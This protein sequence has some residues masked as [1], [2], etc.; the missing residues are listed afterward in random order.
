MWHDVWAPVIVTLASSVGS[1]G[2]VYFKRLLARHFIGLAALSKKLID[3]QHRIE[4][5]EA[6][7]T[8]ITLDPATKVNGDADRETDA[9]PGRGSGRIRNRR[10]E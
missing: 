3:Y 2:V 5:L 4:S 8:R 7:R 6:W 9:H 1:L 10:P